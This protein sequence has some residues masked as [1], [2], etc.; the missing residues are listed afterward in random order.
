MTAAADAS[1][2]GDDV[3]YIGYNREMAEEFIGDSAFWARHLAAFAG[4]VPEV[5]E[6]VFE[7]ES[8][9][10][11]RSIQAFRIR[12]ASGFMIAALSSRPPARRGRAS[13][14]STR[15]PTTRPWPS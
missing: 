14:S 15:R 6:Y 11:K 4:Q 5:E 13:S 9:D 7:D 12:F 3:L 10:G 1:A 2:D 8:E